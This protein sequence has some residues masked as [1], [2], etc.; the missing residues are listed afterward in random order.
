MAT[1]TTIGTS[2]TIDGTITSKDDIVVHGKMQGKLTTSRDVKIAK[3]GTLEADVD[4]KTV[5]I[6]GALRGGIQASGKAVIEPDGKMIG[7]IKA[8]RILIADGA[9]FTGHIDMG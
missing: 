3:E 5:Q 2:I 6:V 8:P 7:D 1:K 9:R 4:A